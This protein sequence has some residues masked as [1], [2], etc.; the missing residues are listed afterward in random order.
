[1]IAK[2]VCKKQGKFQKKSREMGRFFWIAIICT[3]AVYTMQDEKGY[4]QFSKT[5]VER[6]TPKSK[7]DNLRNNKL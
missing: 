6:G 2:K 4:L 1:M 7:Q 5:D 3:P